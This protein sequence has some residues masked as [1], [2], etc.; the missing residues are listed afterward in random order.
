MASSFPESN[1]QSVIDW[2]PLKIG[3]GL[4]GTA[5]IAHVGFGRGAL[6]THATCRYASSFS[7]D[8]S[9]IRIL[10]APSKKKTKKIIAYPDRLHEVLECAIRS[11]GSDSPRCY[12]TCIPGLHHSQESEDISGVHHTVNRLRACRA[13]V[14]VL[15]KLKLSV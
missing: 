8:L 4:R 11:H 3:Q 15:L 1:M 5:L 10:P 13:F 6:H 9:K 14:I 7:S 12:C 2:K